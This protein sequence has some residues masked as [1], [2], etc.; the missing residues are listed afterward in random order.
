MILKTTV[1]RNYFIVFISQ[2]L[3]H[4]R[5]VIPEVIPFELE[6]S[7][8]K[9]FAA[10]AA[11][12]QMLFLFARRR[13]REKERISKTE[14]NRWILL[15]FARTALASRYSFC[16]LL[17]LFSMGQL[18]F[19]CRNETS[20]LFNKSVCMEMNINFLISFP[21]DIFI[22]MPELWVYPE[23]VCASKKKQKP[24]RR[25]EQ[26]RV[27]DSLLVEYWFEGCFL[28]LLYTMHHISKDTDTDL[29]Y[30][31][32][33]GFVVHNR[34]HTHSI[35]K[36]QN[37]IHRY[38]CYLQRCFHSQQ[39]TYSF[40]TQ[41]TRAK[42]KW[43]SSGILEFISG[44]YRLLTGMQKCEISTEWHGEYIGQNEKVS[45]R[46]VLRREE[47]DSIEYFILKFV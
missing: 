19:V 35:S 39:S 20:I 16:S 23:C 14:F 12:V 24:T 30:L 15:V 43:D 32:S 17:T 40:C 46:N 36:P 7:G 29:M 27:V 9:W 37:G 10:A 6:N 18:L 13:K 11:A 2:S 21:I 4:V 44:E 42:L 28:Y 41:L 33:V 1:L 3:T 26:K 5:L 8:L 38:W 47:D 22:F 31:Y 25:N 45:L 34:T